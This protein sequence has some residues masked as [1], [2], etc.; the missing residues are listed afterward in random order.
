MTKRTQPSSD[1]DTDDEHTIPDT[2]PNTWNTPAAPSVNALSADAASV[3]APAA[4]TKAST[5]VVAMVNDEVPSDEHGSP[6]TVAS[7]VTTTNSSTCSDIGTGGKVHCTNRQLRTSHTTSVLLYSDANPRACLAMDS[8]A[9]A[10]PMERGGTRDPVGTRKKFDAIEKFTVAFDVVKDVS[11]SSSGLASAA[12]QAA[13]A[14]RSV[15]V[16]V[17]DARVPDAAP[18]V[19]DCVRG[20]DALAV[21][22]TLAET[23]SVSVTDDAEESVLVGRCVSLSDAVSEEPLRLPV[24]VSETLLDSGAV[25]DGDGVEL[26][27]EDLSR[28]TEFVGVRLPPLVERVPVRITEPDALAVSVDEELREDPNALLDSVAVVGVVVAECAV[29]VTLSDEEHDGVDVSA[30][31]VA[32]TDSDTTGEVVKG[33]DDDAGKPLNVHVNDPVNEPVLAPL[34]EGLDER[35]PLAPELSDGDAVRPAVTLPVTDG[36]CDGVTTAVMDTVAVS[37]VWLLSV[38]DN[39]AE[40]LSVVE[41][42]AAADSVPVDVRDTVP[43]VSVAVLSRV[44]DIDDVRVKESVADA[45][46]HP[47]LLLPVRV[48]VTLDVRDDVTAEDPVVE[49]LATIESDADA[50]SS[51]L[52]DAV[53]AVS[54]T[55]ALSDSV[56]VRNGLDDAD[57]D[58]VV[59]RL[60]VARDAVSVDVLR[61]PLYVAVPSFVTDHVAEL[62]SPPEGVAVAD[63]RS[64]GEAVRESLAVSD[65]ALDGVTVGEQDAVDVGVAVR[66]RDALCESVTDDVPVHVDV[67]DRAAVRECEGDPVDVT[68]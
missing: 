3:D 63:S 24:G 52:T 55:M 29:R 68:V 34:A 51:A 47:S 30:L 64:D 41:S 54:V 15:V 9:T 56:S 10:H 14:K 11:G 8:S 4:A 39:V 60:R 48:M 36:T 38:T 19:M 37:D 46:P 66:E 28:D 18:S 5:V 67:V 57:A 50:E 44:N 27:D 33:A 65:T 43:C 49:A 31:R 13:T 53:D 16:F 23:V 40:T 45:L 17:S 35:V 20:D 62:D 7:H 59:V 2:A 42:L 1:L 32:V 21:A 61:L 58:F 26:S 12:G 25:G 22:S 6:K